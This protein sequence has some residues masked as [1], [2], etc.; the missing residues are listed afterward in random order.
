MSARGATRACAA[1]VALLLLAGCAKESAPPVAP[2]GETSS[3]IEEAYPAARST[4]VPYDTEVW[5]RFAM[6][7]DAATVNERTVFLK[8]DT[9]RIPVTL[10]YDDATR[11]IRLVPGRALDLLRTHTVEITPGVATADGGSLGSHFW[12][13]RT[14][15]LRRVEHPIPADGTASESPFAALRWAGTEPSAGS[16]AYEVCVG[17][18]SAAVAARTLPIVTESQPAFVPRA[19][20][21]WSVRRYWAVTAINHTTG[22]R[23][24]SPVW[25]FSTLPAQTPV[26]SL[27]VASVDWG[28]YFAATGVVSCRAVTIGSGPNYHDAVRW[29]LDR[30]D[31]KLAGARLVGT[32]TSFPNQDFATF[33][34]HLAAL[35]TAWP[36]C[37]IGPRLPALDTRGA[38]AN[39]IRI[40]TTPSVFFEGQALT[41]YLEAGLRFGYGYGTSFRLPSL[42]AWWSNW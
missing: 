13:F 10:S 19:A 33:Q 3:V 42:L 26:D 24:A 11:T 27:V 28:H 4:G 20:W 2:A 41:A 25:S 17:D 31:V 12:Q 22:E 34:L 18:D 37:E 5:A 32:L 6:K 23:L 35:V 16:I 21:G 7:L 36:P 14:N 38:L 39:G 30:Q 29:Q 9:V 40:G 15:G 1:A 8:L